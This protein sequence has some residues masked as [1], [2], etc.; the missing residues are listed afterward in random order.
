MNFNDSSDK[1]MSRIYL[2]GYMGSGKTTVGEKLARRLDLQ[3]IDVDKF[4]ENRYRKSV[5]E[6]FSEKG[7]DTFR[8][9]EHSALKEISNFE[10]IVISTGGGAPCFHGTMYLMNQTGVTIYLKA[11][12]A[13]L[14]RRLDACKNTRPLIKNRNREE[15]VDFIAENLEKRQGYYEQAQLIIDMNEK[16][17]QIVVEEIVCRISLKQNKAS[18]L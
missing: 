6:I 1:P 18:N 5:S 15:L 16:S 14:A 8:L 12:I 10:N 9:I 13:I 4:I 11:S 2:I 3:F 7:E 17:V